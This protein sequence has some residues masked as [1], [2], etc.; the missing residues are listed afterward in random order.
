MININL[1][2]QQLVK[3][4]MLFRDGQLKPEMLSMDGLRS[5]IN[6]L[7]IDKTKATF[8]FQNDLISTIYKRPIEKFERFF[9]VRKSDKFYDFDR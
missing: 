4:I 2:A 1:K 3:M 7:D 8:A 9:F 5:M 6:N